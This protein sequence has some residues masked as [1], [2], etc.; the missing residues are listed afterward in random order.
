MP[1][2][3]IWRSTVGMKILMALTGIL[4]VGFVLAHMF[5]NLKAF[6]G[7]ESFNAY[8]EFLREVGYPAVP[9]NGILWV[10]RLALLAAVGIHVWAALSLTRLSQAA[11]AVGY[12][13][14]ESQVFS[15]ASRTMRW[16]GIIIL[17]FVIYHLLHMTTG[18]LHPEFQHGEAYHNL[19]TGFS[20][21]VV[22]GAYV[23]A[24]AALAFHLHHGVWSMFQTLGASSP[25][26]N[27]LRRPLAAAIA[28]VTFLGFASVPI[29]IQLG[30]IS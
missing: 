22:A 25:R 26:Y 27:H 14:V 7:A 29:S 24:V 17:A 10:T 6:A 21:P 19:V 30:I 5:G 8:A 18:Q 11:R 15:Y 1:G 3:K 9:H 12:R 2:V 28:A 13:K 23:V 16:G 20:N 4:L